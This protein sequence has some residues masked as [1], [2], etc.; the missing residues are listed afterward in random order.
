MTSR[1]NHHIKF[2]HERHRRQHAEGYL[3]SSFVLD[4]NN[5]EEGLW[6]PWSAPSS[7]SRSCG[8]GVAH[9]TRRCLDIE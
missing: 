9:Q 7:C 8:G 5:P 4:N 2:R 6:G 1:V 3:P